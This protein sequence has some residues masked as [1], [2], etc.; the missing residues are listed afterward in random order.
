MITCVFAKPVRYL[1]VA[2]MALALSSP[3]AQSAYACDPPSNPGPPINDDPCVAALD[4]ALQAAYDTWFADSLAAH[5]DAIAAAMG[6]GSGPS[7]DA[8]RQ[9]VTDTLNATLAAIDSAYAS[10]V[11]AAEAAWEECE[12]GNPQPDNP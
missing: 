6:C 2:M 7:G 3:V 5:L 10:A 1:L 4:A 9:F 8:C 12:F 11:G